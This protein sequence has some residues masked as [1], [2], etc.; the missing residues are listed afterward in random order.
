MSKLALSS[1]R[2]EVAAIMAI[3]R[4]FFLRVPSE[5]LPLQWSG[6]QSS[7]ALTDKKVEIKLERRKNTS[8]PVVMRR[9]CVCASSGKELCP[10]HLLVALAGRRRVGAVFTMSRTTFISEI[11]ELARSISHE[12]ASF[13][14]THAFRR[15][16][17][18]DILAR[19]G[20]LATLMQAGGW[21]SSAF[22]LYLR[23]EQL[24][25]TAVG[26]F[27]IEV[28]SSGEE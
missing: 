7:V 26:H 28:S 16:M 11:R 23:N 8:G 3:S 1:G 19:G 24:Q 18:R 5:A 9:S 6:Q 25:D 14:G 4:L 21:T 13:V 20:S 17:A 12:H 27:L 22:Q 15:G 2:L 10:V